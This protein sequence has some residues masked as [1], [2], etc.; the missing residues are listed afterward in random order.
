MWSSDG[1]PHMGH[2]ITNLQLHTG[3]YLPPFLSSPFTFETCEVCCLVG[4]M[5]VQLSLSL[6]FS[7]SFL[8]LLL[9]MWRSIQNPPS[10]NHKKHPPTHFSVT[11]NRPHHPPKTL[12]LVYIITSQFLSILTS[13]ESLRCKPNLSSFSS[14]LFSPLHPSTR[15]CILWLPY[16]II[17]E[18]YQVFP[19]F[20]TDSVT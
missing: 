10:Q 16:V 9:C 5:Y 4:I 15:V 6:S 1:R 3:Q 13:Y 18:N 12:F 20:L 19:A 2:G 8:F 17:M 14:G 11:P 7:T